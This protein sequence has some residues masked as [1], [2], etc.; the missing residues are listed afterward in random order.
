MA[1]GAGYLSFPQR[2]VGGTL[3]LRLALQVTLQTNLGLSLLGKENGLVI[4]FRE[5]I[6]IA[7]LLHDRMAV[8]AGDAAASMRARIPIGLN[9]ALVAC[10]TNFILDLG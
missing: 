2:H 5:L 10:Q 4:N 7:R 9:A 8:N 3:K 1:I 6:L